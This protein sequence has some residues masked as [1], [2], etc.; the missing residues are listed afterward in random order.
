MIYRFIPLL[1]VVLVAGCAATASNYQRPD[2]PS[3]NIWQSQQSGKVAPLGWQQVFPDAALQQLVKTALDHNRDLS[4][5]T[6]NVMAYEAQYRIQRAALL[7]TV[8]MGAGGTR[9]R[10]PARFS[11]SGQA[12]TASQYSL[13]LGTT[14]YELD[15]FGR[16]RGLERQAQLKDRNHKQRR[17]TH[18]GVD[19]QEQ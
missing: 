12:T 7:P 8:D 6:L 14:A 11:T 19:R 13:L 4:N 1:G 15:M 9:Q 17:A 2:V 18:D 3:V 16:V 10:T 5:A